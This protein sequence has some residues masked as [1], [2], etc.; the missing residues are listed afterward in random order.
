M[1]VIFNSDYDDDCNSNALSDLKIFSNEEKTF[2]ERLL[3]LEQS[4][5]TLCKI[6]SK[7]QQALYTFIRDSGYDYHELAEHINNLS[8]EL[9]NH[10]KGI[11]S[12]LII[13]AR[14][15]QNAVN[16]EN[17]VVIQSEE[18]P[19]DFESILEKLK[20]GK[21]MQ[22]ILTTWFEDCNVECSKNFVYEDDDFLGFLDSIKA[23]ID[24]VTNDCMLITSSNNKT[25]RIP[26]VTTE[27]R[28]DSSLSKEIIIVFNIA[29]ITMLN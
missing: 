8:N 19:I 6:V 21:T 9:Y 20:S 18:K 10:C 25:Y 27:N 11:H 12:R 5:N 13:T 16:E 28:F 4:F 23:E 1:V 17:A 7:M 3:N 24:I 14:D 15:K 26:I 2:E 29:N 22:E